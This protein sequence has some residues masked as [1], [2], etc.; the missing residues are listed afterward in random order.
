MRTLYLTDMDG[1]FLNDKGVVSEESK[2]IINELS[3]KGLLF[4]VATARSVISASELLKGIRITAPAVLQSGVVIYDYNN[5]TTVKY[6]SLSS[7][8]FYSIIKIFE[9][10]NKAPFAFF[11]NKEN[12]D[13]RIL[14]TD[15]KLEEHK[16]YYESRNKMHK[17][18]VQKTDRYAIPEGYKP[19][20]ISLCDEYD[21]LVIIKNE[22]DKLSEV[23]YSFYK[24]TYTPYWFLEVFNK[25]AS[26]A[27]GLLTVKE[28]IK[29][30]KVVAFGDNYNDFSLFDVAEEKY[31]VNNAVEALKKAADGIILSNEENGV[32]EFLKKN[33]NITNSVDNE[34]V[35]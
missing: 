29:A 4:S 7:K 26:K 12:E 17:G 33:F 13:Y 23:G 27:N 22:L 1:T 11:F 19:I 34:E 18:L 21:D 14:F 30:D 8:A 35:K 5:K 2:R 32:A 25:E 20:F 31:A 28:Y 16:Q 15:L 9:E 3:G 10:N 24:D 6:L